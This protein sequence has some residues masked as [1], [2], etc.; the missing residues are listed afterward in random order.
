MWWH[1]TYTSEQALIIRMYLCCEL[2]I[3]SILSFIHSVQHDLPQVFIEPIRFTVESISKDIISRHCCGLGFC[4]K[5]LAKW[6]AVD[7]KFI[8]FSCVNITVFGSLQ[9]FYVEFFCV[10]LTRLV[11]MSPSSILIYSVDIN[12]V[13]NYVIPE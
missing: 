6:A 3:I 4:V 9:F 2:S 8:D 12:S 5:F 10:F 13:T 1:A 7:S 11:K